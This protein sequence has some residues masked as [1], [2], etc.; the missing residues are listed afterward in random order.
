[1]LAEIDLPL[2]ADQRLVGFENIQEFALVAEDFTLAYRNN[3][4]AGGEVLLIFVLD[5]EACALF[6]IPR[7]GSVRINSYRIF[8]L[9]R[10]L[11]KFY[12]LQKVSIGLLLAAFIAE[13]CPQAQHSTKKCQH[14]HRFYFGKIFHLLSFVKNKTILQDEKRVAG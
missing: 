10:I 1:M 8:P 6:H 11:P 13:S 9:H 3:P 12:G 4:V 14:E 2:F 5:G 7:I